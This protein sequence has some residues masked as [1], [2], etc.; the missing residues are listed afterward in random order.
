MSDVIDDRIAALA[1]PVA[2]GTPLVDRVMSAL[3][4]LTSTPRRAAAL[5]GWCVALVVGVLCLAARSTATVTGALGPARVRCGLDGFVYGYRDHAVQNACRHAEAGRLGIFVPAALVVIA[6][7]VGA[8]A[9]TGWF[10]RVWRAAGRAPVAA[11]L[12]IVGVVTIPVALGALRPVSVEHLSGGTL[13]TA[14]CGADTYYLGYPDASVQ[15]ACRQAYAPHAHLLFA[16]LVVLLVGAVAAVTLAWRSAALR[17]WVLVAGTATV[18]LVVV[19]A[20]SRPVTVRVG[21]E[22]ATYAS[23]GLDTVVAGYPDPAV[24]HAC[25]QRLGTRTAAGVAAGMLTLVAGAIGLVVVDG[26]LIR[27]EER[28]FASPVR[29]GALA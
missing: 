4:A 12:V 29:R 1:V 13:T 18:L 21:A 17:R 6:G 9:I 28:A 2:P 19:A 15:A 25:R 11:A 8:I 14:H 16:A 22:P 10:G 27:R 3:R 23:C 24:Q 7:M 20:A 5:T 26:R